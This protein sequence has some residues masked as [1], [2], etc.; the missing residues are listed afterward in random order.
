M[1]SLAGPAGDQAPVFVVLGVAAVSNK[2]ACG[3]RFLL[4]AVHTKEGWGHSSLP[5]PVMWDYFIKLDFS[6]LVFFF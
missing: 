6:S 2:F 1:D 5:L 3:C 4:Q